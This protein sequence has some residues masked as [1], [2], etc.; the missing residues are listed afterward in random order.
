M[1]I[2]KVLAILTVALTPAAA[3]AV[4]VT[5][6]NGLIE[7]RLEPNLHYTISF[8][9]HLAIEDSPLGITVDG[10]NLAEGA[11]IGK[12]ESYRVEARYPWYGVHSTAVD[13]CRGVRI[14]VKHAASGTA[15][16]LEIRAYDD[17]IA[18]R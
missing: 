9:G 3:A 2:D 17:G 1:N 18:F 10:V 5:S 14:A 13:N 7:M 8:R 6:P 4:V 12:V 16:T 11:E 15:Y